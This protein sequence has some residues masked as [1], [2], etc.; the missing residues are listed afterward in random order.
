MPIGIQNG[1]TEFEGWLRWVSVCGSKKLQHVFSCLLEVGFAVEKGEWSFF[2]E[3]INLEHVNFGTSIW[4][5][6]S[7]APVML[8]RWSNVPSGASVVAK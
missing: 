5:I 3:K 8:K 4:E 6:A 7:P 1:W 2:R